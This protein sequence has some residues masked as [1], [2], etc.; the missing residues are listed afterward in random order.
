MELAKPAFPALP[1]AKE[2]SEVSG[3]SGPGPPHP[4]GPRPRRGF[5]SQRRSPLPAGFPLG[6][7]AGRG[8]VC[9]LCWWHPLRPPTASSLPWSLPGA[10][11]IPSGLAVSP[12]PGLL[13]PGLG[14]SQGR[15]SRG[16]P[17]RSR[18][19]HTGGAEPS[20]HPLWLLPTH[21]GPGS[22]LCVPACC[23]T[24]PPVSRCLCAPCGSSPGRTC[25]SL[26]SSR[27]LPPS[28][29]PGGSRSSAESFGQT[30]PRCPEPGLPAGRGQVALSAQALSQR[31]V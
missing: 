10:S 19:P 23:V 20:L 24:L 1:Q 7:M 11:S 30:F 29:P 9:S 8:S 15:G 28:A 2:D 12:Y 26:P 22:V 17:G 31:G 16:C 13:Q 3:S 27:C 25:E 14:H 18:H 21:S 4:P 6:S 5:P